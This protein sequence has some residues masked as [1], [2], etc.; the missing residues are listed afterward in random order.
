MAGPR[1]GWHAGVLSAPLP[2]SI[3]SRG[4]VGDSFLLVHR[5]QSPMNRQSIL[6]RTVG[7]VGFSYLS[8]LL[9]LGAVAHAQSRTYTTDADF[10]LGVLVQVNHDAPNN[11]Q[12]Q[13]DEAEPFA[14]L[15]VACGGLDTVVRINTTTGEILGEYLTVPGSLDGDPSRASS[16]DNGDVWVGNRLEDGQR[17]QSF[18]S[19][20]KFGLI[21]GGTR[22]NADGTPNPMGG[23]LMGPFT[24]NTCVDRDGDGLIRTSRGLGD[25]LGWPNVTDGLGG[26]NGLVEDALDECA[27]IFQRTNPVRVRHMAIDANNNVWAGGYPT[28]PTSFDEIDGATGAILSNTPAIPPGCGGYAGVFDSNGVMW[29]TSELEGQL[30]RLPAGGGAATCTNVQNNVRGVAVAPDGFIW[31][32]GGTQLARVSPDGLNVQLFSVSG[33][34]QLHDIKIDQASGEIWVA[35]SGSG[36]V[37]RLDSAANVISSISAGTQPRSLAMDNNGKMW[38]VNQ[39]SDDAMRIDPATNAVDMTVALR[40]GSLAFNPSEMI[41]SKVL[42][43]SSLAGTW[44]VVSDGGLA[45]TNWTNVSWT[46]SVPAGAQLRV[47][48][49]SAES[50]GALASQLFV[51]T[52][53]SGGIAEIGRFLEVQAVFERLD[54]AQASPVLF[55]LSVEGENLVDPEDCIMGQR[56]Q[57]GSLL[58]FPEF[59][60]VTGSASVLTVTNVDPSGETL[61][62]E[63]VY[64]DGD[65]CAEFNRTELLTPNDTLTLLTSQHNPQQERGYV[66]VFVKDAQTGEAIVSNSLIGEMFI[67]DGGYGCDECVEYAEGTAGG[68]DLGPMEYSLNA[69]SFKG[70]GN[71]GDLTDVNLN[72]LRD[73]DDV[74]Y[75]MAPDAILVPR[76]LGQTPMTFSGQHFYSELILVSLTGGARFDTTLDFLVYNDNEE[77]FSAEHTFYCWDKVPLLAISDVFGNEFLANHTNDDPNE[78]LGADFIESG[79]MRLDGAVANSLSTSIPDPAFL[80]VLV[81]RLGHKGAADLAFEECSQLGGVL[82]PRSQSGE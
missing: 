10:D 42:D 32:A 44:S 39:G 46:D 73:L 67:I 8:C 52:S 54:P 80:A 51:E 50:L 36:Q 69:V 22:V 56:R 15:S 49:R 75:E 63:F 18:G 38:V 23:Y 11:D 55:D 72:G 82:L 65:T 68:G 1:V 45:G 81:E 40:P 47:F 12:L 77:G 66:Y 43:G 71:T 59:D 5:T 76:F 58:V 20:A 30:F 19:V 27:L 61:A 24:C 13:L 28:F 6:I 7:R 31:T 34:S 16:A 41:G 14:V 57:A 2:G 62:V 26:A 21:S 4:L 60:N 70:V 48:V 37:I 29:S 33:A 53:N 64:I 25:V 35:S 3:D 17:A 79:W 78:V 9:A 74:E